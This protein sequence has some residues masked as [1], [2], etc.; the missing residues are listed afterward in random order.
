MHRFTAHPAAVALAIA[1]IVFAAACG[2]RAD[3]SGASGDDS[4]TVIQREAGTLTV[5]TSLTT[6]GP[7]Y[8]EGALARIVL[9]DA[10]GNVVD[11]QLK[12]PGKR[13]VFDDLE[14]GSYVVTSALR[15]C[16]GN[17]GYLDPPV[18]SCEHTLS[19]DG[20]LSVQVDF[21]VGDPCVV[22]PRT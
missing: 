21:S 18:D 15:P 17:C 6:T 3:D 11:T 2:S 9:R 13:F 4:A 20:D 5:A 19:I 1:S 7:R 22:T 14:P 16:D 10:G 12:W 8:T